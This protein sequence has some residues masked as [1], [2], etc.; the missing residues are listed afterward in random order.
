[1]E[2]LDLFGC[3]WILICEYITYQLIYVSKEL[4]ATVEIISICTVN[5]VAINSQGWLVPMGNWIF[6]YIW[7][8]RR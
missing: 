4:S 8:L 5:M 2:V 6:N 7:F 1:M 3:E